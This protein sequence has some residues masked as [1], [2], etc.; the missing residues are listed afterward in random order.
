M[1][2]YKIADYLTAEQARRLC[3]ADYSNRGN[4]GQP[5]TPEGCCPFGV[6]QDELQYAGQ[7]SAP[8]GEYISWAIVKQDRYAYREMTEHEYK[9]L[10][11]EVEDA[12]D[13]F[14]EDWD[15]GVIGPVDLPVVLG[16]VAEEVE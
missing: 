1:R 14:V 10:E 4:R 11:G 13:E 8:D 12:A 9:T 7:P 15:D 5:I 3:E 6:L 2:R 16:L